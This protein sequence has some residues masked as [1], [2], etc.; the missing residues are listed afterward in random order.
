MKMYEDNFDI[1]QYLHGIWS[2]K[3]QVSYLRM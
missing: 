1:G 2:A 3:D